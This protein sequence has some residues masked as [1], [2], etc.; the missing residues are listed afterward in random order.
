ME[1]SPKR[2]C[3]DLELFVEDDLETKKQKDETTE[4]IVIFD[5][6]S[7]SEELKIIF[8]ETL[9]FP[10]LISFHEMKKVILEEFSNPSKYPTDIVLTR[11]EYLLNLNFYCIEM[12]MQ[13]IANQTDEDLELY[14]NE[15]LKATFEKKSTIS[16]FCALYGDK[17][18]ECYEN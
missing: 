3:A 17:S 18:W 2:P 6:P 8:W 10:N 7:D 1:N 4:I 16:A 11:I 12:G 13:I 15:I 5:L 9:K 14:Q